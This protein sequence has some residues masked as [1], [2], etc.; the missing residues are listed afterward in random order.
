[1][2]L[3]GHSTLFTL[4]I[5]LTILKYLLLALTKNEKYRSN[6]SSLGEKGL[7]TATESYGSSF[8][9]KENINKKSAS[10]I[11]KGEE[12]QAFIHTVQQTKKPVS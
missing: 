6:D 5:Y 7:C 9:Y 3:C 1:M 2:P 4:S 11:K 8:T 12:L 10:L